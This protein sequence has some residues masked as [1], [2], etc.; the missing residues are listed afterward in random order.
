[1]PSHGAARRDAA[2]ANK[3]AAVCEH[4]GLAHDLARLESGRRHVFR[5]QALLALHDAEADLLAFLQ[6]TKTGAADRTEMHEHVRSVLTADEAETLAF[7][8]PLDGTD[9][10]I[11][12]GTLHKIK[13]DVCN[14]RPGA[15]R[16]LGVQVFVKR[17]S[18]SLIGAASG[19]WRL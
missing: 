1:M 15:C 14:S 13:R 4:R 11:R 5:L 7:V 16:T 8:E 18:G 17:R 19:H 9:L 2:H 3:K 6:R 10:T 12:H